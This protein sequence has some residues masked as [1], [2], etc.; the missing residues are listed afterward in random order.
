M[1]LQEAVEELQKLQAQ[2]PLK[3]GALRESQMRDIST[4]KCPK[5]FKEDDFVEIPLEGPSK[6]A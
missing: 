2:A 3:R 6:A 5:S 4:I 1:K